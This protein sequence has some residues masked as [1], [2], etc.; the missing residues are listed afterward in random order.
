MRPLGPPAMLLEPGRR[1]ATPRNLKECTI[2][3]NIGTSP[4]ATPTR[5]SVRNKVGLVLAVIYSLISIAAALGSSSGSG[6]ANATSPP[7]AVLIAV[8]V[9]GL[10]TLAAA[11]WSWSTGSRIGARIGAF[12]MVISA[13]TS[14]PAFLA[15]GVTAGVVARV[16]AGIVW[17]IVTVV[18]VLSRPSTMA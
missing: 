2:S 14:V 16:T 12:A 6:L 11:V 8:G 1:P 17:A 18:L 4:A 5:P 7:T 13:L 10:I 15:A 3:A 9:L